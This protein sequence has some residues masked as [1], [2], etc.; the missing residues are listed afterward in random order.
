MQYYQAL[1]QV[2]R[3][4]ESDIVFGELY[5]AR[6]FKMLGISEDFF[7]IIHIS[8]RQIYWFFGCRFPFHESIYRLKDDCERFTYWN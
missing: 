1:A 6:E 2:P 7:R 3:A 8:Q 5:T 4:G